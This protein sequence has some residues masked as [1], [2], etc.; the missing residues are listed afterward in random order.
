MRYAQPLP[1]DALTS[2]HAFPEDVITVLK[3]IFDPKSRSRSCPHLIYEVKFSD[4][5]GGQ[6][7][8]IQ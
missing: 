2:P 5:D 7:V 1:P 8:D 4:V 3:T 6:K